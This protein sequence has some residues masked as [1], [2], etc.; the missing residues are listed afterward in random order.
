MAPGAGRLPHHGAGQRAAPRGGE[1]AAAAHAAAAAGSAAGTAAGT[2]A[3]AGHGAS[4]V[5]GVVG[6][7]PRV[8]AIYNSYNWCFLWDSKQPINGVT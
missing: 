1:D 7:G 5:S 3:A 2:A 4:Q 8:L 6:D